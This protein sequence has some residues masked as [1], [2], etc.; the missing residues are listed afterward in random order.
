LKKIYSNIRCKNKGA[1]HAFP[2]NAKW[3]CARLPKKARTHKNLI[4]ICKVPAIFKI[5]DGVKL[6]SMYD[7]SPKLQLYLGC[8]A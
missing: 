2:I 4:A 7:Y 1:R 8:F 6:H 5:F 3:R